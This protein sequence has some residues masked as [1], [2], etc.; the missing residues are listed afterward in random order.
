MEEK[1]CPISSDFILIKRQILHEVQ[2]KGG[3]IGETVIILSAQLKCLPITS[4]LNSPVFGV[5]IVN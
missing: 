2:F 3:I 4:K 5:V 1:S